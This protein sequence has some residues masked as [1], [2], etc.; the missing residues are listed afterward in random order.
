[1]ETEFFT[2]PDRRVGDVIEE[3]LD[4]FGA[5]IEFIIVSAFA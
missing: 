3:H 1:V 4:R 2:Q 5:P